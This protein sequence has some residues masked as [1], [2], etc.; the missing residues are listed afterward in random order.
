MLNKDEYAP[1]TQVVHVGVKKDG[2]YGSTKTPIYQTVTF[3]FDSPDKVPDHVYTRMGNPTREA[4]EESINN[5]DGGVRAFATGG[6]LSAI[7]LALSLVKGGEHIIAGREIY[8]GTYRLLTDVLS[9]YG[10]ESSFVNMSDINEVKAAIRKN[11]KLIWI[12]TPSNPLLNIVD[13]AQVVELAK[14]SG[15]LTGID[16]TF[17]TPLWQPAI[18]MG[19]D[20]AV[21]ATS[22]YINGHGDVLGGV[23]VA[24]NENLVEELDF[25]KNAFALGEAP[26]EAWMVLRGIKTLPLRLA[27]H[28]RNAQAL[29]DFLKEQKW[30]K[31]VYYPGLPNHPGHEIAKRQQKSFGGMLSFELDEEQ[32]DIKKLLTSVNIY[33]LALSLG[34]VDSLIS[35]P[36]EMSFRVLTEEIRRGMGITRGLIRISAG[37]EHPDDLVRDLEQAYVKARK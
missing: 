9:R 32:V 7:F 17:M 37:I 23:V 34:S 30:V 2:Q 26:M 15:I 1:E 12:E 18:K 21:Y 29:V 19:V 5:L 35:Q 14:N 8:G 20:M 33:N 16:N 10:V 22:K 31:R 28:E 13:I 4:L 11:T 25:L 36:W 24:G 27:A 3:N 6:G